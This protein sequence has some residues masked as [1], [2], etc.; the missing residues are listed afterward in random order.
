MSFHCLQNYIHCKLDFIQYLSE[1]LKSI[2]DI[3]NNKFSGAIPNSI[4]TLVS[5][6]LL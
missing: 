3:S 2:R 6:E 1:N 4:S 5:L